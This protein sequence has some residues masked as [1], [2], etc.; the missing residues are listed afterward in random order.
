[1][2]ETRKRSREEILDRYSVRL[3][4]FEYLDDGTGDYARS[5]SEEETTEIENNS[6]KT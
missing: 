1:M 3:T 5:I 4:G 6:E 2:S